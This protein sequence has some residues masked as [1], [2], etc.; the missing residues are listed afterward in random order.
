MNLISIEPKLVEF[1]MHLSL[2]SRT[3]FSAK[4]GDGKTYFLNEFKEQYKAKYNFITIYPVNYQIADNKEIFEYIKRDILIQM[5][6][7]NMIQPKIEIPDSLKLQFY[8]MNNSETLLGS[9]IKMLP[10]L[11][12]PEEASSLFVKGFSAVKSVL[13]MKKEV[14]K[15]TESLKSQNEDEIIDAYLSTFATKKGSPYEMDLITYLIIGNIEWY[16]NKYSKKI[17][18][19]IEDLDRLDPAHLFRILNVF[20]AHI[21]RVYQLGSEEMDKS[22]N[23]PE[24]KSNKFGFDNVVTVFDNSNAK[25]TFRYFYGPEAN[26]DG[27]I[28]K[29]LTTAP[30]EYSIKSIARNNLI[31]KIREECG[32]NLASHDGMMKILSDLSVRDVVKIMDNY[33]ERIKKGYRAITEGRS[34]N[35]NLRIKMHGPLTKLISILLLAKNDK[36]IV[37][38]VFLSIPKDQDLLNCI[39]TFILLDPNISHVPFRLG[40]K[41][42]KCRYKVIKDDNLGYDKVDECYFAEFSPLSYS[43]YVDLDT[44]FL[45]MCFEAALDCLYL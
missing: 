12:F 14:D 26:Y 8:M 16:K 29:F 44:K 40:K 11:G 28:S 5:I 32:I 4:F 21:D 22:C 31:L 34:M 42:Y 43:D 23:F 15:Y 45:K 6:M 37:K 13:S 3:I 18:L 9:L 41:P 19:V 30:F 24:L 35:R 25:K 10:S 2:N 36:D 1:E 17:V 38:N 7:K 33:D 39:G 20:S 27:Y